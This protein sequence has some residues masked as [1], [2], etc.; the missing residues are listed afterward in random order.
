[1]TLM[2]SMDPTIGIKASLLFSLWDM[3]LIIPLLLTTKNDEENQTTFLDI[4]LFL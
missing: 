2:E 4:I 3:G 1:M